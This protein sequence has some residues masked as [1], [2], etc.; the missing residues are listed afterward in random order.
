MQALRTFLGDNTDQSN[1]SN[2]RV[3]GDQVS[4]GADEVEQAVQRMLQDFD[5]G[6]VEIM[7]NREKVLRAAMA[8][9][10]ILKK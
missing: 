4:Q 9:L 6:A 10:G 3:D 2:C 7:P 5:S 1:E 8:K